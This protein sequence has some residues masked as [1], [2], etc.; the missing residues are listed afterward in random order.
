M[1]EIGVKTL[2]DHLRGRKV[3]KRIDTGVALITPG[4][5]ET[6]PSQL[7]LHPPLDRYL[8]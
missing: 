3:E 2:I 7:L 4:N 8:R 6:G 5:L 1:G